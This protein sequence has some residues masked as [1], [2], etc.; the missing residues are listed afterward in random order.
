MSTCSVKATERRP[1]SLDPENASDTLLSHSTLTIDSVSSSIG[2]TR[3]E[4]LLRWLTCYLIAILLIGGFVVG[5]GFYACTASDWVRACNSPPPSQ[6]TTS[7]TIRAPIHVFTSTSELRAAV[8]LYLQGDELPLFGPSIEYW[9]VSA[10]TDFSH[11]FDAHEDH[12]PVYDWDANLSRWDVSQAVTMEAMFRGQR[13]FR[14]NGLERW[15]VSRVTTL[16]SFAQDATAFAADLSTWNVQRVS[17]LAYVV[18]GTAFRGNVSAWNVG[19]VTDMSH[20]FYGATFFSSDLRS[21]EVGNVQNF[22][23]MFNECQLFRDQDLSL[24]DTRQATDM[25]EMFEQSGFSG[26]IGNWNVL[27]VES[28]RGMFDRSSFNGDI[29]R[30]NTASCTD[31]SFMFRSTPFNNDIGHWN[32]ERVTTFESMFQDT[33]FDQD[34]SL[35]K[36]NRAESLKSMFQEASNFTGRGLGSWDTSRVKTMRSVFDLSSFAGDISRWNTGRVT[37]FSFAFYGTPFAGD[38][39]AWNTTSVQTFK[40]MVSEQMLLTFAFLGTR[41]LTASLCL[42]VQRGSQI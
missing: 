26:R 30:W 21:W 41:I 24:W 36:M 23:Y 35:W 31:M 14:G 3:R 39:A 8:G 15:D 4:R 32:V 11:L 20:A 18:A 29:G 6:S 38:L 27:R 9:N 2:K 42:L 25:T 19:R 16:R 40:S 22:S 28:M 12:V 1:H 7:T 13:L 17:D 10:I 5:M 34:L 33:P 37:D